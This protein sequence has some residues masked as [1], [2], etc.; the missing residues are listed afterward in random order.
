[1]AGLW[2]IAANV[3]VGLINAF[4]NSLIPNPNSAPP[5]QSRKSVGAH[6]HAPSGNG[7][8]PTGFGINGYRV[9]SSDHSLR[10]EPGIQNQKDFS[11]LQRD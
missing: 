11:F 2:K 4:E 7:G 9:A 10:C 3:E 1:M 5:N 6:S 8:V